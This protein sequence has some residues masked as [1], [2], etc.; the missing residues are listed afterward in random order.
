MHTYIHAY[1]QLKKR[2]YDFK[3]EQ[4]RL[5]TW[6]GLERRKGRGNVTKY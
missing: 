1:I 4:D 2:G 3:R 5:G 6:L